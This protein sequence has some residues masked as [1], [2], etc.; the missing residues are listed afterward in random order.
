MIDYDFMQE[1][2]CL[3]ETRLHE[4]VCT[5]INPEWVLRTLD[6]IT[7]S[8]RGVIAPRP[9]SPCT[10]RIVFQEA[11]TNTYSMWSLSCYLGLRDECTYFET[12]LNMRRCHFS[13]MSIRRLRSSLFC[14]WVLHVLTSLGSGHSSQPSSKLDHFV[15]EIVKRCDSV[16]IRTEQIL[17]MCTVISSD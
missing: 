2:P 5:H 10:R 9:A 1:L 6:V 7:V 16:R 12:F 15:F 4:H 11:E 3:H 14:R 8:C 17:C 13:S